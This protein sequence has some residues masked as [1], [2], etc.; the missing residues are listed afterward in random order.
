[1]A[2]HDIESMFPVFTQALDNDNKQTQ[3]L[4]K[5]RLTELGKLRD[6]Y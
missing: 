4:V 5:D 1:V 2:K 6:K 3:A